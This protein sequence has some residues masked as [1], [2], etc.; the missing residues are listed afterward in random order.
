MMSA[1]LNA[2]DIC[3][4]IVTLAERRMGVVQ[5]ARLMRD[6]HVGCLVVVDETAAGRRVV[7]VLTDRDIV[8]AV[9][10][11]EVDAATLTVEDLMSRDVATAL[12]E[13]SITDLL[14]T[15]RHKGLRRMPVTT[16][17]GILVGL[18]TIDDVLPLLAEQLRD[19]ALTIEAEQLREHRARP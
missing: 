8:T 9:V 18:V 7:G 12:G 16:A 3:N 6:H 11:K 15:M 4:R 1:K 13:D 19:I 5:A 14:K 10:A 17:Q 2:S